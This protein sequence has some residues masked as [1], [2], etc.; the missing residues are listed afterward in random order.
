MLKS[1]WESVILQVYVAYAI[2]FYYFTLLA[3]AF[4]TDFSVK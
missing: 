3:Y 1:K 2:L 4:I